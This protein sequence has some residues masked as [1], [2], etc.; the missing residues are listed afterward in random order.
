MNSL[1]C[2]SLPSRP[3][4]M[5]STSSTPTKKFKELE[6]VQYDTLVSAAN[7]YKECITQQEEYMSMKM[8]TA[9]LSQEPIRKYL[10]SL[11]GNETNFYRDSSD[12][13]YKE[14]QQREENYRNEKQRWETTLHTMSSCFDEIK[15][16]RDSSAPIKN[17]EKLAPIKRRMTRQSLDNTPKIAKEK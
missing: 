4:I 5:S 11:N 1:H 9:K 15:G 8:L 12:R 10:D 3:Q 13:K 6:S 2:N 16:Y 17:G 7:N 14:L